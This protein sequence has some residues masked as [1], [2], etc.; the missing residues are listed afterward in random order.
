[1]SWRHIMITQNA[2][3]SVKN[4][5][6]I[7][8]REE[9]LTIPL[10]DIASILI[11]APA[12]TITSS[13]L[14]QCVD[15]KISLITCSDKKLPNGILT[16][17][18]QHSRQLTVLKTQLGLSKPFKK[19]IWQ[20]I[21]VQ[22]ILNQAYCLDYLSKEGAKELENIAKTVESGDSSNREAYAARKYFLYLFGDSF[23]R[24]SDSELNKY[25][26]Y[27]YSIMR[28]AVA[29]SLTNYGFTT[30]L[31]IDHDNQLNSFNLADDFMEVLR[32]IVDCHVAQQELDQWDTQTKADIVNLLNMNV[33]IDGSHRSITT[34][35]DDITKSF[36][37]C[38]RQQDPLYL[39]L[40]KVLPLRV[41][42][43][44]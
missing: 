33:Y 19:R 5:Q 43:Y 18:H 21:V 23:S 37:A 22:K 6:L 3:L 13:L 28:S 11:E 39:K 9:I 26:N 7:I 30:C 31:G 4:K 36:I 44:E 27:G 42:Q 40:P 29:R 15:H 35:I 17:Y 20:R 14:S 10:Q 41:H 12:V 1:M 24:R 2:R 16:G 32:P 8:Q 25:L 38:C 34:A